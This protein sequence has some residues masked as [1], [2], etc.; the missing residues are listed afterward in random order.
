MTFEKMLQDLT[1]HA[2]DPQA[3]RQA[4]MEPEKQRKIQYYANIQDIAKHPLSDAQLSELTAIVG[5]LQIL[6]NSSV[7]S[8]ITDH[9]YDNMQEMLVSMGIPR[10]TGAVE[11]N[12]DIKVAHTYTTL[13]GTLA[14][15]Y[16]LSKEDQRVNKNRKYLDEWVEK[17]EALYKAKTGLTIHLD[18]QEVL[19]QPKFDGVSCILE[20]K[21]GVATWITRGDTSN[22]MA[23]DVTHIMRPF[24]DVFKESRNYG[25]K[26]EVMMTEENKDRINTM[27]LDTHYKNSRQIVTATINASEPDYK[28]DYL[29]PVPLRIIHPGEPVERIHPMLME[30]FPTLRCKLKDRELIRK[31]GSENRYVKH[32][33]MRF[34]T[35][36]AVITILDPDIQRILGRENDINNF[37]VAY[38]FT[39]ESGYSKVKG[40]EF[41][42]SEFGRVTPVL[43]IND[44][45]L[46]G[47]TI[48]HITLSNK[49]RFDELDLHYGDEVKVLY[50][51]IPYVTLDEKCRRIPYGRKIEFVHHC[52]SCGTELDLSQVEV[53]C[54]NPKCISRVLGRVLN[55]CDTLRIQNIGY[56]TLDTLWVH[57]CLPKGIR[58]LY[59]LRK[60]KDLIQTLDGFGALKTKKII[61]EIEAKRRLKD[62]D[63]FGALGIEGLS[64]KT[65]QTIFQEVPYTEVLELAKSRSPERLVQRLVSIRGIG[66]GKAR[67]LANYLKEPENKKELQKLLEE[68]TIVSTYGAKTTRERVVFTGCRPTDEDVRLLEEQGYEASDSWSNKAKFLIVPHEG[69]ESSKVG[70]AQALG[71]P[72]LTLQDM[73]KRGR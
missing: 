40:V 18:E 31:F 11:I 53:Q 54:P 42:V 38:K 23:S 43:V 16:Y 48:N 46:K 25:I 6:E 47:N 1:L 10:L 34:R 17:M 27:L 19:V 57:G 5:I 67:L 3:V 13:R 69:Y 52:P 51:I 12:D 66:E 22:N 30:Q 62:Y 70:K 56:S 20:V 24:T 63:F 39:E 21:D 71:I 33:N 7:G 26:F 64:V 61:A 4:L 15:V 41:Y 44:I 9:A 35:D 72:I 14:K 49:E 68:L 29:Y 60:K 73:R 55:Y 59:K 50:D 2:L 28:V 36:G 37:E 58:S 8:P 45:I 32:N 65:F